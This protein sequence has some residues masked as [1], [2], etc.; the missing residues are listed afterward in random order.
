M[1]GSSLHPQSQRR[2]SRS[3]AN[4][5]GEAR[6]AHEAIRLAQQLYVIAIIDDGSRCDRTHASTLAGIRRSSWRGRPRFAEERS[7]NGSILP[8]A[9]AGPGAKA[10][11]RAAQS[12]ATSSNSALS[13]QA[14]ARAT[15][16]ITNAI[17][18]LSCRN[19]F[20]PVQN[21]R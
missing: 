8:R 3:L 14:P 5:F 1:A 15:Y 2:L 13:I 12:R 11:R 18:F 10:W 21:R 16:A 7:P 4:D 6:N 9:L 20:P 17:D 19:M